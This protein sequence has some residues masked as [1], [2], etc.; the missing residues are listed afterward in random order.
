MKVVIFVSDEVAKDEE[1]AHTIITSL[2]F[3][4]VH[5][6]ILDW[7]FVFILLLHKLLCIP[8]AFNSHGFDENVLHI[9]R[10]VV[11]S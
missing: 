5:C 2:A 7:Y 9:V 10:T 8:S 3:G 11:M 1:V 6:V 4:S